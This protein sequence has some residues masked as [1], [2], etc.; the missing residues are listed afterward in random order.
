[1]DFFDAFRKDIY[2]REVKQSVSGLVTIFVPDKSDE[3]Q[4]R[5]RIMIQQNHGGNDTNKFDGEI[6]ATFEKQ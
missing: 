3:F 6:V 4:K 5:L 2:D 1:M